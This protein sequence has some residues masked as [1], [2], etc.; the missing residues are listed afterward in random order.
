M[1]IPL[2]HSLKRGLCSRG[3]LLDLC[4]T[5]CM[6][7][8]PLRTN[9]WSVSTSHLHQNLGGYSSTLVIIWLG[10][11]SLTLHCTELFLHGKF[12]NKYIQQ[13]T[14]IIQRKRFQYLKPQHQYSL[15][16]SLGNNI[17]VAIHCWI[18]HGATA[19][20]R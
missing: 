20:V 14:Y 1:A 5:C 2:C 9:S 7:I 15:S 16:I 18:L 4:S 6:A 12:S 11:V 17:H 19:M 13:C 10:T 8:V 3:C